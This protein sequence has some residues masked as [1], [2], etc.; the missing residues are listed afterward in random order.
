MKEK[1]T[2]RH[3]KFCIFTAQRPVEAKIIRIT[4]F[5]LS[6][7]CDAQAWLP[8]LVLPLVLSGWVTLDTVTERS[9][10]LVPHLLV[11]DGC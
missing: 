9:E 8:V 6:R 5:S 10:F 7:G 2:Y 3:L 11:F 4:V 1:S